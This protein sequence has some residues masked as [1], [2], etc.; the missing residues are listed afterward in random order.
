MRWASS[1][2][3]LARLEIAVVDERLYLRAPQN[4]SPGVMRERAAFE[5]GVGRHRACG[6]HLLSEFHVGARLIPDAAPILVDDDD[7]RLARFTR[8]VKPGVAA[9]GKQRTRRPPRLAHQIDIGAELLGH[10]YRLAG[11]AR[12]SPWSNQPRPERADELGASRGY[13]RKPP[14]SSRTPCVPRSSS[15][16]RDPRHLTPVTRPPSTIRPV[17]AVAMRIGIFSRSAAC[18]MRPCIA[19]PDPTRRFPVILSTAIRGREPQRR[20]LSFPGALRERQVHEFPGVDR[21]GWKAVEAPDFVLPL[22]ELVD[23]EKLAHQR[24]AVFVAAGSV[25]V[26]VGPVHPDELDP[27]VA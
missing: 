25:R 14:V 1:R 22:A 9:V 26:V 11:V 18:S 20:R 13:A 2:K 10:L 24:A 17:I 8:H 27:L 3:V 12:D 4:R 5:D 15:R 23:V 21:H 16:R 19:L 7:V 6:E